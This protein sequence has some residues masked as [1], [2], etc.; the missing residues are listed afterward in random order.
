[1][2]TT[3]TVLLLSLSSASSQEGKARR[4]GEAMHVRLRPRTA[5]QCASP[6]RSHHAA[7]LEARW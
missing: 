1:M 4:W 2:A 7:I 6:Q 3:L 5:K